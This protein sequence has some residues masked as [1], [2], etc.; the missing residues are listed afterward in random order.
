MAHCKF[1]YIR[2]FWLPKPAGQKLYESSDD[3]D[4]WKA[5]SDEQEE[6]EEE[7]EKV[8]D[9]C[10]EPGPEPKS[11]KTD[12]KNRDKSS[13]ASSSANPKGKSE[14]TPK[15][16][17]STPVPKSGEKESAGEEIP[18]GFLLEDYWFQ[19]FRISLSN[20]SIVQLLWITH[21]QRFSFQFVFVLA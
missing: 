18:N 8:T 10:V 5:T 7:A 13:S 9:P 21:A 16:S 19:S 11:K 15:Q 14:E 6:G 1:A 2:Q 4:A 17:E 3:E 20:I 12:E